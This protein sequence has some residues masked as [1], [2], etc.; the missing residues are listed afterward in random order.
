[1]LS[2]SLKHD[3][4]LYCMDNETNGEEE[5]GRY[6]AKYIKDKRAKKPGRAVYVTEMWDDWDLK[7]ERHRRR[8]TIPSCTTSSTSRRTT[9]TR[10][11]AL[12]ERA[13]GAEYL[14]A[15]AAH[16]HGEDLRRRRQQVRTHGSG[17]HR[18]FWRHMFAGF[19]S[20][21]FH[22]PDSGLGLEPGS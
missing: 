16:Q 19:A 4:V 13:V 12:G 14:A 11:K 15:A 20:A 22:R 9:T 2:Y 21:R 8:S 7:A 10:A 3:H 5:W 17:R 6:W 18:A 1:M